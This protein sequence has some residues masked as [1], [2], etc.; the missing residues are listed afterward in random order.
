MQHDCSL[1]NNF[2]ERITRLSAEVD[3][4]RSSEGVNG[5]EALWFIHF[6]IF[7]FSVQLRDGSFTGSST[8]RAVERSDV[9]DVAVDLSSSIDELEELPPVED[10]ESSKIA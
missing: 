5:E 2:E 7:S 6:F 4:R 8:E 10:E 9:I 1:V 3:S